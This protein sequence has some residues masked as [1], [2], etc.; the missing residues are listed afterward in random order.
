MNQDFETL[1]DELER[2]LGGLDLQQTQLRPG[3]EASR[4]NIQQIVRHLLLTY[5][6]TEMA[7]DARLEKGSPTKAKPMLLQRFGQF[8]VIG[9]E[10]FP[11]GRKAPDRVVSSADAAAVPSG[12]LIAEVG[13]AIKML[14]RKVSAAEKMFGQETRA[15]SHMVLGPLTS[16]Q[17]RRFHLVHG[18]HHIKQIRRIRAEF[19]I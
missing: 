9:L 7:I 5:A 19:G 11:H 17:W 1:R 16:E 6:A 10:Y 4:W 15:V 3:G 12:V 14:D 2:S 18:R 8:T 13:E